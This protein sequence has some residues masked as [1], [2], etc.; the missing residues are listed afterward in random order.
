MSIEFT[1]LANSFLFCLIF[2]CISA[3]FF[4]IIHRRAAIPFRHV[5]ISMYSL[6]LF[7]SIDFQ[8]KS[9]ESNNICQMCCFF[10]LHIH[11][12]VCVQT[13]IFNVKHQS[14]AY[15]SFPRLRVI[16]QPFSTAPM[17]KR[18]FT[19]RIGRMRG[20]RLYFLCWGHIV[21]SLRN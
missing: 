2:V 3:H 14:I 7:R 17:A 1:M 4:S 6:P 13:T 21:F 12:C 10:S 19:L 8:T 5:A 9:P 16:R 18:K 11:L 20:P 15:E